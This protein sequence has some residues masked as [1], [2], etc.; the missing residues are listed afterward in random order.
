MRLGHI[1]EIFGVYGV[2]KDVDLPINRRTGFHRGSATV[3]YDTTEAADKAIDCMD[4]GMLDSNDIDVLPGRRGDAL[5]PLPPP[6]A[7]A[8]AARER[9]LSP[10]SRR[11]AMSGGGHRG[12]R[13]Y[14]GGVR[15]GPPPHPRG[16]SLS[17]SPPP[18]RR[19]SRSR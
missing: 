19:Y 10:Y 13:A 18:A 6:A 4:R 15:R 11:L 16:R 8:P 3:T 12:G 17:R 7:P 2:I 5:P 9:S 1:E 14:A